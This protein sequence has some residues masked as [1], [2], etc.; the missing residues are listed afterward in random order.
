[1]RQR[2][3]LFQVFCLLVMAACHFDTCVHHLAGQE[4]RDKQAETHR[5]R[6]LENERRAG[7]ST[8]EQKDG[9]N[10]SGPKNLN[11]AKKEKERQEPKGKRERNE[12]M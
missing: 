11:R 3:R 10:N 7:R 4:Q 2:E 5:G 12:E 8:K 1:M 9:P 6:G